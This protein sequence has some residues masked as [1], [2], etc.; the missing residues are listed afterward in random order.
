MNTI[1]ADQTSAIFCCVLDER[2][3][4]DWLARQ[5]NASRE[6]YNGQLATSAW[7][8][9]SQFNGA[10]W[11]CRL[12]DTRPELQWFLCNPQIEVQWF[13]QASSVQQAVTV[14][15]WPWYIYIW[16][17]RH[18][19][20]SD[21]LGGREVDER[22][23]V[24]KSLCVPAA[25]A[26]DMWRDDRETD[27]ST[28][29]YAT[30]NV[31][32]SRMQRYNTQE[33]SVSSGRSFTPKQLGCIYAWKQLRLRRRRS[34]SRRVQCFPLRASSD[35]NCLRLVGVEKHPVLQEL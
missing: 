4:V 22:P 35:Q 25:S 18:D 16:P 10:C 24:S 31:L 33:L 30:Y 7:E 8:R 17:W 12:I 20:L 19:S 15:I 5:L 3:Q 1:I 32:C 2:R 11:P 13:E 26:N 34:R 23:D 29:I 9:S 21:P 27:Q 6:R 28:K 14:Y